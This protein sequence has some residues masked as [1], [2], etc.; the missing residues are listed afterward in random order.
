MLRI[1]INIFNFSEERIYRDI[2]QTDI[3]EKEEHFIQLQVL[4]L[5]YIYTKQGVPLNSIIFKDI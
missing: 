2:L 5:V 3:Q 4:H 1:T